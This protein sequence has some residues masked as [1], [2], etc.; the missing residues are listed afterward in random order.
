MPTH[1]YLPFEQQIE[2]ELPDRRWP[3][4]RITRAPRWCA[5]DLRDGNQALI[6]P[7]NSERKLRM[8]EMLVAMRSEVHTSELQSR[9]HIVCRLPLEK[10]NTWAYSSVT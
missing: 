10:K 1:K 4:R 3:S 5:V 6:D 2:V 8:F 7:M 9:G